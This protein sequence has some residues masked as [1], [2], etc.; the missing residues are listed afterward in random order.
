MINL[1]QVVNN[2]RLAQSFSIE[3]VAGGAFAGEGKWTEGTP[4]TLPRFGVITPSKAND[5]ITYL[6]EGERQNNV[7]TIYCSEDILMADGQ[8]QESDYVLWE[9]GRY[10][11]AF[12]KPW[13]VQGYYFALAVGQAE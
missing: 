2:P 5:L 13:Q 8:G 9:G 1:S 11:V 12:S 7:I 4:S 6:P 3:R 10:R